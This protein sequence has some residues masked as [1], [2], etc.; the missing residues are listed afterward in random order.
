MIAAILAPTLPPATSAALTRRLSS[1]TPRL[2]P[3]ATRP[4]ALFLLDLAPASPEAALALA[5]RLHHSTSR[6]LALTLAIGLAPG[7][8]L[9]RLAAWKASPG[10]T[11]ALAPA[12]IP[13][14]LATC[15]VARLPALEAQALRLHA[16]GIASLGTFAALPAE[17]VAIQFGPA[18]LQAWRALQG[19]EPPLHA[20]AP[21]PELRVRRR[22]EGPIDDRRTLGAALDILARRLA[23]LLEQRA[24][25]ARR[26]AL[27]CELDDGSLREPAR[28]L[29]E[30]AGT[31][32]PLRGMLGALLVGAGLTCGVLALTARA[33]ELVPEQPRQLALFPSDAGQ[34]AALERLAADV[35]ACQG[36][37]RLARAML[38]HPQALLP[39]EQ[40]VLTRWGLA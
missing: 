12:D 14:F 18:A 32:A 6:Q 26:L 27:S 7:P 9:A 23:L 34:V 30:P 20:F 2:M 3:I 4:E 40:V 37:G 36:A 24:M 19:D 25:S 8:T 33:S 21:P 1:L 15:P 10:Q 22:F 29:A 39:E 31:L 13:A 35:A 16:L 38:A 5:T 28:L 11:L 17:A